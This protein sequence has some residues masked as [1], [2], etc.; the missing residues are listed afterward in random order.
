MRLAGYRGQQHARAAQFQAGLE[1]HQRAAQHRLYHLAE[2]V[3]LVDGD[4]AVQP[5]LAH[6]HRQ[7]GD[8]VDDERRQA[9]ARQPERQPVPQRLRATG[10]QDL[11]AVDDVKHGHRA[12]R[13]GA[14]ARH[15]SGGQPGEHGVEFDRRHREQATGPLAGQQGAA[16][17]RQP[18][19]QR[20]R[21]TAGPG[22]V[23]L[24]QGESIAAL[25]GP[26]RVLAQARLALDGGNRQQGLVREPLGQRDS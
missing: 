6:R 7:R 22:C 4:A 19:D 3:L 9:G 16:N 8:S 18:V 5:G 15:G 10:A 17:Q 20:A 25:P 2:K 24:R 11:E 21:I 23:A 13:V 12:R 14:H 1:R 26:Q